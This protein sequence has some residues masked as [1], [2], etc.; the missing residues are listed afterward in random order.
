MTALIVALM[1]LM[2]FF[3]L[4]EMNYNLKQIAKEINLL[5]KGRTDM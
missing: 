5:R 2:I 4:W 3:Q 1:F